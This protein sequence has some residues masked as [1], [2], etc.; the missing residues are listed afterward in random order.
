MPPHLGLIESTDAGETW[1][2]LA[3]QGQADFHILEQVHNDLYAYDATSGRLLVIQDWNSFDEVTRLPLLSITQHPEQANPLLGTT[4]RGRL[5]EI[6]PD[7]GATNPLPGPPIALVDTTREGDLVGI[8]PAG[9]VQVS[10]DA[11]R[12]WTPRGE[13]GGQPAALTITDSEW[14]AATED[15]AF[16]SDDGG[17]TWTEVL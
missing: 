9:T 16:R 12:S 5:V 15:H 17:T 8:D 11:G 2:P 7:T 1:K 6:E 10:V 14:Y 13:I 3:L 4:Y